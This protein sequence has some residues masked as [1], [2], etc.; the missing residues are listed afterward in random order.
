MTREEAMKW[1]KH[2]AFSTCEECEYEVKP[3][4]WCDQK[5][6]EAVTT[7]ESAP[8]TD[9]ISRADA[10]DAL[11]KVGHEHVEENLTRIGLI[12][13][14]SDAIRS[15]PSAEPISFDFGKLSSGQL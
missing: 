8:Q 11:F 15:L 13:D 2:C 5:M 14:Y 12:T 4:E 6:Q 10:V 1:L 3:I 9:L 7:I